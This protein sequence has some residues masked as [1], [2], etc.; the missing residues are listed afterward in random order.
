MNI[1]GI[2]PPDEIPL[3]LV[4]DNN[5]PHLSGAKRKDEN[6]CNKEGK[7]IHEVLRGTLD[8]N[9]LKHPMQSGMK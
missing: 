4:T 9:N 7:S 3:A 8:T 5:A 6:E 1:V 2:G